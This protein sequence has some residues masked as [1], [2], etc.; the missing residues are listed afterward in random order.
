MHIRS[1]A[2]YEKH[3]DNTVGFLNSDGDTGCVDE[4]LAHEA[5]VFMA[6]GLCGRWKIPLGYYFTDGLSGA[7]LG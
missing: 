3:S 7:A 2:D 5:C 6:V 4:D 1:H